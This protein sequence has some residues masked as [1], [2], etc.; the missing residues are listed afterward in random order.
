MLSEESDGEMKADFHSSTRLKKLEFAVFQKSAARVAG[1][2]VFVAVSG[3]A[4]SVALLQVLNRLRLRREGFSLEIIHVHHGVSSDER[5]AKF[6]DRAEKK[7]SKLAK[8][9]GLSLHVVRV[10]TDSESEDAFREARVR[11]FSK[12]VKENSKLEDGRIVVAL[13]HHADDLFE[14]RLIRLLRGTGPDG[15]QGMTEFSHRENGFEIWRPFLT[16]SRQEILDYLEDL[17]FLKHRDWVEDPSNRNARYLRNKVRRDLIPMIEESR[18]GGAAA[19]ARSLGLLAEA[20]EARSSTFERIPYEL[21]RKDLLAQSASVQRKSLA[22]W[23][24]SQGIR[25]LSKSQIEEILRRI[26]T[27]R[28]RLSFEVGGRVWSVGSLIEAGEKA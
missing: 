13:A 10:T 15:L 3:G 12:I 18:T 25:D 14:T 11:A 19:M 6:R 4:D 27:P 28:K 17:E 9:L 21:V 2:R 26:D 8:S 5:Q 23:A 24:R 16:N 20:L 1:A 22:D 7:V